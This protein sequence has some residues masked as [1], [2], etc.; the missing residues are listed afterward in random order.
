MAR[1]PD[2]HRSLHPLTCSVQMPLL[3]VSEG[4]VLEKLVGGRLHARLPCWD[5]FFVSRTT[6]D[7]F[8]KLPFW[9]E[10]EH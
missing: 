7:V 2:Q 9:I 3:H 4:A 5:R 1:G 8:E 6:G 10:N